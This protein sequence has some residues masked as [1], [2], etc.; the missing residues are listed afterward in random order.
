MQLSKLAQNLGGSAIRA[1]YNEALKM[2]DTISFTVGEPDFI[3]PKPIIDEACRCWEQGLTHYTPNAGVLPLRQ[4]IAEYHKSD[5]NPDPET[6]I[7]VSC[8]ATEAIQMALF[9]LVDPGDEVIVVTPAWPNYFGQIGMTGAT[10]KVVPA[11]E[12][13]NFVPDPE[14]IKKAIGPKTKVIILN[15]PSNPTG[16]VI[17]RATCKALADILV[18]RDIYVIADEIYSR[19]VYDEEGYTSITSFDGMIDKTVYISGFSKMFAMTGWRLGYAIARPDI[20]R[21]MTK[22]HENGA[23]CLPAPSQIAA[24]VGL[25][26]CLPEIENMRK[27]Y[28]ERRNLICS[29]INATPGLSI[30]PPKGAFY[31]FTNAKE[32]CHATGLSS[33]ELCMDLLKK[34]GVVTVPGSGFGDVGEGFV[35][36]TY[37]TST[38]NIK[39]GFERIN[40]YVR[41]LG[42]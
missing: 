19:L 30:H 23:S 36:I 2:K 5:L 8:G 12:E 22:L 28:L 29:L 39:A 21:N 11:Y 3:T 16:A 27:I 24:A 10:L 14:D 17:D 20:I 1:M 18:H 38:E 34:I 42:L 4:A 7:M 26:Q 25:K 32:L 41:G 6:Q 15:S 13:N 37:A 40:D 31:A 9:T 35:R 33:M